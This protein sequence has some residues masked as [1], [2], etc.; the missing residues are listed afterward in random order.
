M[1][2]L[3]SCHI[4]STWKRKVVKEAFSLLSSFLGIRWKPNGHISALLCGREA[5][6]CLLLQGTFYLLVGDSYNMDE[7]LENQKEIT[8]MA[9]K[10]E[11]TMGKKSID[12]CSSAFSL[13]LICGVI[14]SLKTNLLHS[15]WRVGVRQGIDIDTPSSLY[16][17]RQDWKG[18]KS[19]NNIS[20]R[21]LHDLWVLQVCTDG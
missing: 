6:L 19:V 16:F 13:P 3:L 20:N 5:F 1:F 4:T 7:F 18:S 10:G 17:L 15:A 8:N 11:R 21:I 12:Q 2:V 9:Q 14:F